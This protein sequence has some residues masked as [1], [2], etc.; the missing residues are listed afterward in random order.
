MTTWRLEYLL[1]TAAPRKN[2]TWERV[3]VFHGSAVGF[4]AEEF[5]V[6]SQASPGIDGNEEPQDNFGYSLAIGDFGKSTT[7]DLAIGVPYEDFGD[8]TNAGVVHI[9]YSGDSS[10][11]NS[12]HKLLHQ[13]LTGTAEVGDGFGFSLTTG[14]FGYDGRTDLAVSAPFE[15]WGDVVDAG[16]V[17]VYYGRRSGISEDNATL[18]TQASG[19]AGNVERGDRFGCGL[20]TTTFGAWRPCTSRLD[21]HAPATIE[22]PRVTNVTDPVLL[23]D[24]NVDRIFGYIRDRL[25]DAPGYQIAIAQNG[26]VIRT[27]ASGIQ[28]FDNSGND[29]PMTANSRI[30]VGSVGKM[31]TAVTILK[32]AEM[33][34]LD[35][36]RPFYSYLSED[37]YNHSEIDPTVRQISVLELL[38]HTSGLNHSPGRPVTE[39]VGRDGLK[40]LSFPR[41]AQDCHD[42]NNG[43]APSEQSACVRIYQNQNS[44]LLR[45][46]IEGISASDPDFGRIDVLTY[47]ESSDARFLNTQRYESFIKDLWLDDVVQGP[48]CGA[49]PES[50]G[51]QWKD[52]NEDGQKELVNPRQHSFNTNCA[53]GGWKMSSRQLLSIM[54]AIRNGDILSAEMND[55]L[56]NTEL[57]APNGRT[58]LSWEKPWSARYFSDQQNLGK[59][60]G[61]GRTKAYITRLPNNVDAVLIMNAPVA[62]PSSLVQN[63]YN[64]MVPPA[65]QLFGDE[66]F[67]VE[68]FN[69]GMFVGRVAA[70]D[71]DLEINGFEFAIVDG[72]PN[73]A[74]EI[75]DTGIIRI[76]DV[77]ALAIPELDPIRLTVRTGDSD[78]FFIDIDV[79]ADIHG[80]SIDGVLLSQSGNATNGSVDILGNRQLR[81]VAVADIDQIQI[82]LSEDVEDSFDPAAIQLSGQRIAAY[83]TSNSVYDPETQSVLITLPAPIQSDHLELRIEDTINDA[84]GNALDGEW[85]PGETSTSSGDDLPGGS[86]YFE[87]SVLPADLGGD[88]IVGFDD[89]LT[90]SGNF[91]MQNATL[92]D[93]DIDLDGTV[94]FSDFLL[95]SRWFGQELTE[96]V[97]Q[98]PVP[99]VF[100]PE[101]ASP[102]PGRSRFINPEGDEYE[103]ID[104][105]II[106]ATSS[107]DD[108]NG[109][110]DR[111]NGTVL[112]GPRTAAGAYPNVY[113]VQIDP[114]QSS[115]ESLSAMYQQAEPNSVGPVTVSGFRAAAALAA[116]LELATS[117]DV[118]VSLN[119][120]QE[121]ATIETGD[122][123]E[124]GGDLPSM[125]RGNDAFDWPYLSSNSVQGFNVTAAWQLL[126]SRDLLERDVNVLVVDGGFYPNDDFPPDSQIVQGEWREE[127]DLSCSGTTCTWHG[128]SVSL[129]VAGQVDNDFGTAGS[130]GPVSNLFAMAVGS[131]Y[132]AIVAL[133]LIFVADQMTLT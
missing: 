89:F 99:V 97:E 55:L 18:L 70:I 87:F 47:E 131:T 130:A 44:G 121:S 35:L 43:T 79:L 103:F 27:F 106:V 65:S 31:I 67:Q 4:D 6:I 88:F 41:R 66:S 113:L 86:F 126:E 119:F 118:M 76:V 80:P 9:L 109:V 53:A 96:S 132:G 24:A 112:D 102:I 28:G 5:D 11:P 1:K 25:D 17:H 77:E 32:L 58:A 51:W 13:D 57:Q 90:L 26:E 52:L 40:S 72:D 100:Q 42:I 64:Q 124:S 74:F 60:G 38:T 20:S 110:L 14:N 8:A 127:N 63:A 83:D 73:G 19:A 115:V 128:T 45:S 56:L 101:L 81:P 84:A 91:G 33:G 39:L 59:S 85:T 12:Q 10:L 50:T 49:V 54:A 104:N 30:N 94:G 15:N 23:S 105:Q 7:Q 37:R 98:S 21:Y 107:V 2:S 93:G 82:Q 71:P 22:S 16:V 78:P 129:T 133:Y 61:T 123:T 122:A 62:S 116:S 36:Y 111:F 68:G 114:T 46:V 69:E 48:T 92:E 95:L 29:L 75:D 125:L 3:N 34:K 108:I 120:I 117:P